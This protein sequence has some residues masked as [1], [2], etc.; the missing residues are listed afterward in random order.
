M[1]VLLT[2]AGGFIGSHATRELVTKGHE[3]TAIVR[4][5]GSTDRIA[6]VAD[7]LFLLE[8][9]LATADVGRIVR[10]TA[11]DACVHL[12]WHVD[13]TR[14]LTGVAENLDSLASSVRLLAALSDAGVSRVVLGG[15]CLEPGAEVPRRRSD[16][17]YA[18]AKMALHEV[19]VRLHHVRCACAH[20]FYVFGPG[21]K[22]DRV[23]PAVIRACLE[24]RPIAVSTG[25]QTRD[26]LHVEDVASALVS[27][28]VSDE[29]GQVDICSGRPTRLREVFDAIGEAT[30][31]KDLIEIGKRHDQ[32][33]EPADIRGDPGRLLAT[34]WSPRWSLDSGILDAVEWWRPLVAEGSR[35][36]G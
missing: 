30:G 19:G 1:R 18:G 22:E 29:V 23:V 34:G 7:A 10:S 9:D 6:D 25:E 32:P 8:A 36:N 2:G 11:P 12:A 20:I 5:G 3:V 14:Y 4:P 31:R 15:T 13:P 27:V 26:F 24:G 28:L 33:N 16:T 35:S 17:I 21:E